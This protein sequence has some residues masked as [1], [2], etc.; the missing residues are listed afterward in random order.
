MISSS[1]INNKAIIKSLIGVVLI[2]LGVVYR[3]LFVV[4]SIYC[5]GIMPFSSKIEIVSMLCMWISFCSIFKLNPESLSMFT[6]LEIAS[7]GIF[8]LRHKNISIGTLFTWCIYVLYL[9]INANGAYA[10]LIKTALVPIF[11]Y[12]MMLDIDYVKLKQIFGCYL[13]GVI[14]SSSIGL[15]SDFIPNLSYFVSYKSA[16]LKDDFSAG[17]ISVDRF[18]GLW[19]DPNYYSIHLILCITICSVLYAR[20]EFKEYEFYGLLFIMAAFGSQTASKSFLFTL[21]A[22]LLFL[23]ISLVQNR[24]L[25]KFGIALTVIATALMAILY[26]YYSV[27]ITTLERIVNSSRGGITTGRVDIWLSYF[28]LLK[29]NIT[30]LFIGNGLYDSYPL[31]IPHNI[32]LD[33]LSIIGIIGSF[34][35]ILSMFMAVW[36]AWGVSLVGNYIPALTLAVMYLFISMFYS[37]DFIF[38]TYLAVGFMCLSQ[39]ASFAKTKFDFNIQQQVNN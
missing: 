28:D 7:I 37:V 12:Y 30:L 35:F 8:A 4:A 5:L 2:V 10:D 39:G 16:N 17:Y 29:D 11:F 21:C 22:V 38:E 24:Q 25:V 13:L 23:L 27:F 36:K 33:Y 6:V 3:P 26:G 31:R 18:S 19:S 32:I 20:K 9:S 15:A 14:I 1:L 34:L